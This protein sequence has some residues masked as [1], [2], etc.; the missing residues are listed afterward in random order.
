MIDATVLGLFTGLT[1][2]LL[3][4]GL[5]LV[6][7]SS[8]FL[9]FA[10]GSIGVFGAAVLG[11]LVS[12]W[13]VPYWAALPV[14][15]AVG[16]GVAA[17]IEAGVVRRLRGR[18]H[19]IG[20]I[21][22][23]GLSQF[24]LIL[25]LLVNSEGLSGSRFPVP[26]GLPSFTIGRT[27]IGPAFVAMALLTPVLLG[28]LALFLRR[29]RHGLA[30][31][32][33]ADAPDAAALN[34]IGPGRM[35]TLAWG[36]AGAVAA[37]SAVLVTPTQGTQSIETLGPDLLLRGLAGAVAA[38]M[39]S[40]PIAFAACLG[41][42]VVEQIMLAE[43]AGRG[44]VELAL[45]L[46]ILVA[47]LSQPRL[48][49]RDAEQ[50]LWPRQVL[51][52]TGRTGWILALAGLLGAAGLAYL[53]SNEVASVLTSV[54]G[55]ALVGLSV[56]IV[57]GIAGELSLGQFAFAGIGAAVSLHAAA[58]SGNFFLA[59]VAGCAAAA[60]SAALVGLPALRLRGLAL[61][62]TTLAFALATSAW[63]LRQ[64]FLLGDGLDAAKP[65]W[66]GYTLVLA[67]DYYLFALLMLAVGL[68]VTHNLR[69]GGLGRLLLA[70]RDNED[71]ARALTV[72]VPLR[73]LQAY[74][75]AGAL[76]GL[77]GVVIGHGQSLLTVN[78]FPASAGVD[79]VALS[80]VGGIGL[81]SG[82]L[83]GSALLIGVPGL[84][85]LGIPGQAAL[86]V[87]WLL[88]VVLLPGGLAEPLTKL[89]RSP[90]LFKS[91]SYRGR[92]RHAGSARGGPS[93]AD[94]G[95]GRSAGGAVP[96]AAEAGAGGS[97]RDFA[98][99]TPTHHPANQ[100]IA[101]QLGDGAGGLPEVPW[102]GS[103][104]GLGPKA[105]QV[106]SPSGRE[107]ARDGAG[108][109]VSAYQSGVGEER[110]AR[111]RGVAR[112]EPARRLPARSAPLPVTGGVLLEAR[113]VSRSFGGVRAV[114]GVD[115][116]VAAGEVVGIIGPNGAGKTTLFEIIAG[117][118]APETGSIGFAGRDVT[119]LSPQRRARQGLVRSFQDARLFPTL[120]VGE[121]V[122]VAQ[123]RLAPSGVLAGLLGA[124]GPE[125]RKA[126]RAAELLDLLGLADIADRPV[127]ELSTGTRRLVEL[128]CLLALEPA[129]LLLDEPSSGVSQADG[130][131]LGAL[132]RRVN[133][134]LGVALLIIEHDLPLL[135]SLAGRIV[136]MEAGRVIADGTPDDVRRHPAVVASY[137]G[138]ESAAVH[139]SGA[140]V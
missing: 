13:G 108:G 95:P 60:L 3:A 70:V 113:G 121:S 83:L 56:L 34:G 49:R 122:L 132:L 24:V 69:R 48:G 2:G 26:P 11:K 46:F 39:S 40:L 138:T 131:A 130:I 27:P 41:V 117:F 123:E 38:R 72:G 112:V 8:R 51:A 62:A 103:A 74:A 106:R 100:D 125:R 107:Q 81:L 93:V 114:A 31:R 94:A 44:A 140:S 86:T 90:Q 110:T 134:E 66:S 128:T 32:A 45:A 35:A 87:A 36:I 127:G 82:P 115:I 99:L 104:A 65:Q 78:S 63:L 88:V 61:A 50:A 119:R 120:T 135:A 101:G 52:K 47:L 17:I 92:G 105:Y 137:L 124:G 43:G 19:V 136:A 98:L 64:D 68:F 9:N 91:W 80:V 59:A 29:S 15:L 1:Y 21:A 4:V 6:Y 111:P 10:H 109:G 89:A 67:K 23:L 30:I 55:F 76:A 97:A 53:V 28:A 79:V 126:A 14:A 37:F 71:A 73:R 20:M 58:S 25:A 33:A 54:A 12:G 7:R 5:V 129:L 133:T 85:E 139:R 77:G 75:V 102:A 96:T 42:G 116:R 18:P 118:T 22:T 57:T 16:G 84:V